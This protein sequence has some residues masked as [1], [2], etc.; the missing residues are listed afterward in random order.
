MKVKVVDGFRVAHEGVP[1][2]P[3]DTADVP[4]PVGQEWVRASWAT[5]IQP[6][7]TPRKR[8]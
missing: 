4:N 2:S 7:K 3:G 1:Y 8:R 5:E 6:S